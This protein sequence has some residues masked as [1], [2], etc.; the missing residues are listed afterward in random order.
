MHHSSLVVQH[1]GFPEDDVYEEELPLPPAVAEQSTSA[2]SQPPNSAR[3]NPDL[4]ADRSERLRRVTIAE[5]LKE[6]CGEFV[7]ADRHQPLNERGDR[8]RTAISAE[9][10]AFLSRLHGPLAAAPRL[11][12][13]L[14]LQMDSKQLYF[15]YQEMW[16]VVRVFLP[17]FA[18]YRWDERVAQCDMSFINEYQTI[19]MEITKK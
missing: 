15:D 17:N 2:S 9:I 19:A 11:I 16:Q 6:A 14:A 5:L 3:W 7:Q 12:R 13:L 1:L 10:Y 8:W 4:P 18:E